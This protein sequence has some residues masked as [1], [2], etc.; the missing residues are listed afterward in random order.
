V[1]ATPTA[2]LAATSLE[3]LDVAEAQTGEA[4]GTD[5]APNSVTPPINAFS[6]MGAAEV[7]NR[8]LFL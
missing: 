2:L 3:R 5:V 1:S 7:L 4:A 8:L 6:H